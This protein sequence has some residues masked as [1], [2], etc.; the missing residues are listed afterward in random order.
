M[1]HAQSLRRNLINLLH[2]PANVKGD[3]MKVYYKT[4]L[5]GDLADS[6]SHFEKYQPE[7]IWEYKLDRMEF[8]CEKIK[9]AINDRFIFFG[10]YEGGL[11]ANN[12]L[13]IGVCHP[14][15]EGACWD[16]ISIKIC[17]FCGSLIESIESARFSKVKTTKI[18][19]EKIKTIYVDTPVLHKD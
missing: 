17:P 6:S 16:E 14:Y 3:K 13:N 10:E 15:P 19:P 9:R 1:I 5:V 18:S 11:S 4:F 12:E 8:C 7:S 2:N